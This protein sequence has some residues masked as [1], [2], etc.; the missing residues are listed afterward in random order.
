MPSAPGQPVG[1]TPVGH[2]PAGHIPSES[3]AASGDPWGG[4]WGTSWGNSWGVTAP[5]PAEEIFNR[6]K[7]ITFQSVSALIL[8]SSVQQ[9]VTFSSISQRTSIVAGPDFLSRLLQEDGFILLKEDGGAILK[10]QE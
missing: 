2:V 1:H 7:A 3:V 10:E 8:F 4:S 6:V 9:Q 5:A